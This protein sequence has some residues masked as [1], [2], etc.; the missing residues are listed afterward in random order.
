MVD[1]IT[2]RSFSKDINERL[3]MR[4]GIDQITEALDQIQRMEIFTA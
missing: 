3:A 4:V 2:I 1:R